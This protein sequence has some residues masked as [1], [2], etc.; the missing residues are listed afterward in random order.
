M[1]LKDVIAQQFV[2]LTDF[3][4]EQRIVKAK[5]ALL[6]NFIYLNILKLGY[7]IKP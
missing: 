1:E 4:S 6:Y 2:D 3:Y 5:P 7:L